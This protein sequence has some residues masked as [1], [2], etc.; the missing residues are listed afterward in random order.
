[1]SV[2][3]QGSTVPSAHPSAGEQTHLAPVTLSGAS[4]FG[5]RQPGAATL[6]GGLSLNGKQ[7]CKTFFGG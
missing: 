3:S 4:S 1:M 6:A 5:C 7:W 2:K